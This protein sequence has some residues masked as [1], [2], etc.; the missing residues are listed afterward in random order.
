M[1]NQMGRHGETEKPEPTVWEGGRKFLLFLLLLQYFLLY[2]VVDF[3]L[4]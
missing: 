3:V 1:G 2:F 4:L